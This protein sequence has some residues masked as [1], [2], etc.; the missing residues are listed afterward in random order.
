MINFKQ[1]PNITRIKIPKNLNLS[2]SDFSDK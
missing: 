2:N 1:Y